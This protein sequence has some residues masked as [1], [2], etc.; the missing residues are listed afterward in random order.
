MSVGLIPPEVRCLRWSCCQDPAMSVYLILPAVRHLRCCCPEVAALSDCL[1][2]PEVKCSRCCCDKDSASVRLIACSR[3]VKSLILDSMAESR[4]NAAISEVV[5]AAPDALPR[6]FAI[7]ARRLG[8]GISTV[9][10]VTA[11]GIERQIKENRLKRKDCF[12]IDLFSLLSVPRWG[13]GLGIPCLH[14]QLLSA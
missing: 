4:V 13:F 12:V 1:I 9:C 5:M 3:P 2:L 10:A 14:I 7:A 8:S 6:V 11:N